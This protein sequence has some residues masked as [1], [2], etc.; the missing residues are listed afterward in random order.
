MKP[1]IKTITVERK[2]NIRHYTYTAHLSAKTGKLLKIVA[3]CRKWKTFE[4]AEAH[5]RGSTPAG[6]KWSDGYTPMSDVVRWACRQEARML[7]NRLRGDVA[8]AQRRLRA[9]LRNAKKRKVRR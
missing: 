6:E 8:R 7:L 3:G 2:A 1:K 9:R 5:Y 4:E